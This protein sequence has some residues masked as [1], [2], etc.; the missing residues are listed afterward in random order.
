MARGK[1]KPWLGKAAMVGLIVIGI[2]A[3]RYFELGQYLS[4]DYIKASEETFHQ[5]Y[6]THR[7][8]VIAAYMGIY[9]V[10]TALSLP[11]AAVMTLAGGALFGLVVGTVA[12][13]FASTIGATLACFASRFLLRDWVQ[14]KFGDKLATINAGIEK[15]GAFY[16]FSLRLVPIFP[17]FVIN[18]VMGLT[19]IRL[20]TFFWVSQIGM[21][22]GTIVYVNAGRQLAQ[23]DSLAG[24][25][26]PG[27][28]VSL[29]VL[30]LFPIA[31]KKLLAFY[32]RKFGKVSQIAETT[33]R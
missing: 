29:A 6:Q 2:L 13:S 24:I 19:P 16:L 10:V 30:G 33:E 18:L 4:L 23:I 28:L 5:L 22:A 17:F 7:V 27:V 3:F 20:W 31:G 1:N 26:S 12:V 14:R 11:G 25:L 32:K 21:L 15:E 9:I 8:A